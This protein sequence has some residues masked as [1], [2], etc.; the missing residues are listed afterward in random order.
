MICFVQIG[1]MPAWI[2]IIITAREIII[3]GFRLIC[4]N[5]GTVVAASMLGKLK[6]VIQMAFIIL[7]SVN[8]S[9]YFLDQ[10]PTVC[11][12][13]EI[14]RLILMY[15]ALILT[16]VSLA[17]YFYKNRDNFSFRDF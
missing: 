13:I 8:F 9:Y 16:V 3:S 6:T 12:I 10:I 1:M 4:A 14:I 15:L 17:D 5:K 2:C 7:S 11:R